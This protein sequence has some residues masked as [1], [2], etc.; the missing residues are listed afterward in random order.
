MIFVFLFIF[1]FSSRYARYLLFLGLFDKQGSRRVMIWG[2]TCVLDI[3]GK[4]NSS[5]LYSFFFFF[6]SAL[7]VY[8]FLL[9][10]SRGTLTSTTA[11]GQDLPTQALGARLAHD[12]DCG[13]TLGRKLL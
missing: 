2:I 6:T 3:V 11:F 8:I 12:L 13:V 4:H 10:Y 9:W 1:L 5:P 7:H